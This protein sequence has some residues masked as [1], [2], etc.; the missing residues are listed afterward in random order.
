LKFVLAQIE[1]QTMK[2]SRFS[3]DQIIAVLK[4]QEAGVWR[5]RAMR[6]AQR[7]SSSLNLPERATNPPETNSA[8]DK[9]GAQRQNKNRRC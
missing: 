1:D 3:E 6:Q 5:R 2:R 7:R 4:E 9:N 8:L